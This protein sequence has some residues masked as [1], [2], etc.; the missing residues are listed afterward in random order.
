MKKFLLLATVAFSMMSCGNSYIENYESICNSA[1]EQVQVAS[2]TKEIMEIMTQMRHE[3]WE[4]NE[5]NPEDA[6]RYERPEVEDETLSK[7][8][9]RRM[10]A[11]NEVN[12]KAASKRRELMKK[13]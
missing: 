13:D 7:N 3:L 6:K 9:N 10:K 5:N 2:S 4:L 1:K 11:V 12:A 8:F